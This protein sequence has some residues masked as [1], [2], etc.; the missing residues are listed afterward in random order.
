MREEEE[1][2]EGKDLEDW[3]SYSLGEQENWGELQSL[4][5]RG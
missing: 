5:L 2:K 4:D 1:E 3:R